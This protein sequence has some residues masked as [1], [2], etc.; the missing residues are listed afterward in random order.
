MSA[1]V[2]HSAILS[3]I[4]LSRTP[5]VSISGISN[6]MSNAS[7]SCRNLFGTT[8]SEECRRFAEKEI[9]KSIEDSIYYWEF[10]FRNE[11]PYPTRG[12]YIW[13]PT[14]ERI[15]MTRPTK[16]DRESPNDITHLY[17]I[18]LDDESSTIVIDKDPRIIHLNT[19]QT[20]ITGKEN[21]N[22]YFFIY[23]IFQ[24]VY[25]LTFIE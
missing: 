18:P 5:Q 25:S 21:S 2:F 8:N 17:H 14:A 13:E 7:P 6:K 11:S 15:N 1:R 16:R 10:D 20:K 3:D 23:C 12:K 22:L 19:K 9:E 24:I 4:K